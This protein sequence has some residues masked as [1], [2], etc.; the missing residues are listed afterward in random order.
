MFISIRNPIICQAIYYILLEMTVTSIFNQR[1]ISQRGGLKLLSKNTPVLI[2][3]VAME[4]LREESGEDGFQHYYQMA[5]QRYGFIHEAV[6]K[7]RHVM[8][9]YVNVPCTV[10][11]QLGS[12]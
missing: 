4:N 2:V 6:K 9:K 1:E 10:R 11:E 8:K 3:V 7:I 12:W 5:N